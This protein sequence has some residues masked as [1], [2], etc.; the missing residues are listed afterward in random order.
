MK[1]LLLIL[2]L[3]L[4]IIACNDYEGFEETN[5]ETK[6]QNSGLDASFK[7]QDKLSSS[8]VSATVVY[9]NDV[10]GDAAEVPILRGF[11]WADEDDNF[12][13][14]ALALSGMTQT[15]NSINGFHYLSES[16]EEIFNMAKKLYEKYVMAGANTVRIPINRATS[17]KFDDDRKVYFDKY[18]QVIE[19]AL[20][21][22]NFHV[23]LCYWPDGKWI[24]LIPR[25]SIADENWEKT[26]KPFVELYKDNSRVYFEPLNEPHE[27]TKST[28]IR[29]YKNW[30]SI[31][32][33]NTAKL[34]HR[35][36]LAGVGI[37]E[38]VGAIGKNFLNCLLSYHMYHFVWWYRNGGTHS[39]P[40]NPGNIGLKSQFAAYF[41]KEDILGIAKRTV[42][43]EF[44]NTQT[45]GLDYSS[46]SWDSGV[47]CVRAMAEIAFNYGMG[48]IYWPGCRKGDSYAMF[49]GDAKDQGNQYGALV[50]NNWSGYEL[51]Q[52][53]WNMDT[54]N[55]WSINNPKYDKWRYYRIYVK[56]NYY[57]NKKLLTAG[58]DGSSVYISSK[59]NS[60][61][62]SQLWKFER[63]EEGFV[64]IKSGKNGKC[65]D[66]SGASAKKDTKVI[67][68][69][70]NGNDNQKWL[71]L[72]NIDDNDELTKNFATI[73][74]PRANRWAEGYL[75]LSLNVRHNKIN[76]DGAEIVMWPYSDSTNDKWYI[77]PYY[78]WQD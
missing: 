11:N 60:D 32:G 21:I 34:Q 78:L 18:R 27:Y 15:Y 23:I 13:A 19:A 7:Q 57:S 30:L 63:D 58:S 35:V 74:T 77:E 40:P 49:P 16:K 9:R 2:P 47:A 38:D 37:S 14:R 46:D 25:G 71:I 67:L 59:N 42:L 8:T 24:D 4:L 73:T 64:Y 28:L 5:F 66:I 55:T 20:S 56:E 45:T 26:W 62:N 22:P 43:T 36:I 41:I 39:S 68:Y 29:H 48:A 1:K 52:D 54:H 75:Y 53:A 31:H 3:F 69:P 70:S 33:F 72:Q 50:P 51:L 61:K 76:E 17:W 12:Q 6:S 10:F 44:G 65:L